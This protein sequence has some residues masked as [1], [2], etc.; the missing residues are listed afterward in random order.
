MLRNAKTGNHNENNPYLAGFHQLLLFAG[1]LRSLRELVIR[2]TSEELQID[3]SKIVKAT[4]LLIATGFACLVF[5]VPLARFFA[6]DV[7]PREI[8][9]ILDRAEVFGHA[10]G[11]AAIALTIWFVSPA[12]RVWMPRFLIAAYGS[13]LA[14]DV[15]K[16]T[17][18]RSRPCSYDLAGGVADSFVG[19]IFTSSGHDVGQLVQSS[20]HSLPS[21]HTATAVAAAL[22]LSKI[23]PQARG[24]FLTLAILVAANRVE[25][26]AHFASDVC[27]GAA[28]GYSFHAVALSG[29]WL[30]SALQ[31]LEHRIAMAPSHV[32][33]AS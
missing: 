24:W 25:G 14:A 7:A 3:G 20:H 2:V 4:L 13:G 32:S 16:L 9:A 19:S 8:Q 15:G 17:I 23:Y 11:I 31:K 33:V 26:G 10:Y 1:H 21:A 27:W 22:V 5:D 6:T 28:V 30:K 12:N 18:W 29:G